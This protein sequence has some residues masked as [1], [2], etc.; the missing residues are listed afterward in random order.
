MAKK[1]TGQTLHSEASMYDLGTKEVHQRHRVVVGS[2][3][4]NRERAHVA[5]QMV[6]DGYL[7]DGLLTLAQHQACEYILNQ[8]SK[9]GIYVSTPDL[10]GGTGGGEHG[11]K[12]PR[13]AVIR[14][15]RT[16]D[17]VRS[18]FGEYASYLVEEVVCHNWDVSSDD[19]KMKVLRD[20]LDQIVKAR[21]AV[22]G[23]NPLRHLKRG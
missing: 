4:G 11:P 18:R 20:G 19:K 3:R 10:S 7:I 9:A 15:G 17:I 13:D 23:K 6:F 1:K 21:M 8:A 14:F 2:V 22:A 16:M 12:G 5:D